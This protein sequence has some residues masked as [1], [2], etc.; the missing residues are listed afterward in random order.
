MFHQPYHRRAQRHHTEIS[1]NII[2]PS[3]DEPVTHHATNLSA[4]GMWVRTSFPFTEGQH[5]VVSFQPPPAS[6]GPKDM[7]QPKLTVFAKVTRSVRVDR[8][9]SLEGTLA[10]P[11]GMGLQFC[12]LSRPERRA[13]QRCLRSMPESSAA[14]RRVVE[15]SRGAPSAWRPTRGRG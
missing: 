13:L 4:H 6:R 5:V 11:P 12:D 14:D 9:G 8:P 2:G 1:C 15:R 10:G 7:R 3:W